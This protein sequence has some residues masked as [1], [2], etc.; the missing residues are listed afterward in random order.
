MHPNGK[1]APSNLR[2]LVAVSCQMVLLCQWAGYTRCCIYRLWPDSIHTYMDRLWWLSLTMLLSKLCWRHQG[3]HASI[4]VGG[5][6]FVV[7]AWGKWRLC[8]ELVFSIVVQ[9]LPLATR[10]VH[11]WQADGTLVSGIPSESAATNQHAGN[12]ADFPALLEE[13]P[14]AHGDGHLPWA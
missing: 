2:Q 8:K 1:T 14:K 9:M 6:R 4:R 5:T 10:W 13:G 11:H 12:T 3:P 7:L